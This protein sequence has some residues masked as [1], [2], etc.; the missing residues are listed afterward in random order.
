MKVQAL[1]MGFYGGQRRRPGDVFPLD[2]GDKLASW[3]VPVVDKA[4]VVGD[5]K[6]TKPAKG[7]KSEPET[8]RDIALADS[9]AQ[10]PDA[11]I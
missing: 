11:L 6:P 7:K 5:V 4:P 1:D 2:A 3:M 9:A 10:G 8:L